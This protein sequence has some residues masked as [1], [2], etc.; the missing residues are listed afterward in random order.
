MVLWICGR[1][2]VC[3]RHPPFLRPQRR[4]QGVGIR[5]PI[6]AA[7]RAVVHN[8]ALVHTRGPRS[9]TPSPPPSPGQSSVP[10]FLPTLWKAH[11]LRDPPGGDMPSGLSA[12]QATERELL[13]SPNRP[14]V[15]VAQ[16]AGDLTHP[17]ADARPVTNTWQLT[18]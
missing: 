4:P 10:R 12:R 2:P 14:V 16:L 5:G 17:H 13:D 9:P 1:R 6:G 3:P 7:R 15:V 8:P 11:G 18:V